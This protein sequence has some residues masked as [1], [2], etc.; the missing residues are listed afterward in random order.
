MFLRLVPQDS[1]YQ[2]HI[3]DL[4]GAGRFGVELPE[5]AGKEPIAV[6]Q[7]DAAGNPM[8]PCVAEYEDGMFWVEGHAVRY[9]I[10]VTEKGTASHNPEP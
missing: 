8:G 5:S 7:Y 10:A 2:L 6:A 3:S 9:V 1:G 4:T